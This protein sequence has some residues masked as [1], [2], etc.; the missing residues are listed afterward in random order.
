MEIFKS[1][2]TAFYVLLFFFLLSCSF[3]YEFAEDSA[4][5]TPD[6]VMFNLS[7]TRVKNAEPLV[8]FTASS[9]L[10][11]EKA[12]LFEIENFDFIHYE[13]ENM[14]IATT[15]SAFSASI[16]TD[17]NNISLAGDISVT[18]HVE[19]ITLF[20][21]DLFYNDTDKTLSTLSGNPVNIIDDKGSVI[22][23]NTLKANVR[24]MS[25][26]FLDGIEG[27]Y[28]FED[29]DDDNEYYE[30]KSDNENEDNLLEKGEN[31]DLP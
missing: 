3:N 18:S 16:E 5:N 12:H 9:A 29:D 20:S 19:N 17:T 8:S 24:F 25:F 6:T 15:G 28:F 7:Y 21:E 2:K 23:G 27:V 11:Y 13:N 4:L 14:K 31:N 30:D 1:F 22:T 10:R 26:E